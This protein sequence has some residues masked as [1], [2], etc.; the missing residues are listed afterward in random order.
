MWI[1]F[2]F[3]L[4]AVNIHNENLNYYEALKSSLSYQ[5][6]KQKKRFSCLI[7]WFYYFNI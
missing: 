4:V 6:N 7:L 3:S 2:S 5:K 1:I